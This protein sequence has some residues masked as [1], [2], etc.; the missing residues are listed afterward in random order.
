MIKNFLNI[1]PQ[2]IRWNEPWRC[3]YKEKSTALTLLHI[4]GYG[5]QILEA[6]QFLH[7]RGIIYGHLHSGNVILQNGVAR[8]VVNNVNIVH[9]SS[10]EHLVYFVFLFSSDNY[11]GF[12]G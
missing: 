7:D 3:K 9:F 2:S 10:F 12:R 8:Y 4:Q 1:C 6:L 11:L 5:R